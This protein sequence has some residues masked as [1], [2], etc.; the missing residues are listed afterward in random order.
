MHKNQVF[1]SEKNLP[2][3]QLTTKQLFTRT[4]DFE[5][6]FYWD[7]N[8]KRLRNTDL[9]HQLNSSRELIYSHSQSLLRTREQTFETFLCFF[10]LNQK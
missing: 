1:L 8:Q 10:Y 2:P 7:L 3:G 4:K 6:I 5:K 9:R